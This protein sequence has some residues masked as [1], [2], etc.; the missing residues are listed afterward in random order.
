M[1]RAI[2]F[3][4]NLVFFS[5]IAIAINLLLL[6]ELRSN[7]AIIYEANILSRWELVDKTFGQLLRQKGQFPSIS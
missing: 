3:S 7:T 5:L 1:A 2:L 4:H 6:A